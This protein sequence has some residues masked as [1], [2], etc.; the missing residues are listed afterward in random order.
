MSTHP[1]LGKPAPVVSL[2]NADGTTYELKPGAEGKPTAVFFYPKAGTYGCTRE[3]CG[4]R[5]ALTEK[6]EFKDTGVTVV[7]ISADPVPAIKDFA[8]KHNVTYPMLS[9]ESGEARK[10]YSVGR[11]LMGLSEGR[12]T[13]FI[14]SQGVVREVYDSVIN[15][16]GHIKSISRALEEYRKASNPAETPV[17]AEE[18]A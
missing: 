18:G 16:S 2:P 15:F 1:L 3:V 17:A 12:V 7:G 10:A 11:G 13:F 8:T 9:D 5:D 6:V 14:D 4:F